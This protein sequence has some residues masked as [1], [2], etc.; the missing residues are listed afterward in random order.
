MTNF[1][2]SLISEQS[3]SVL[4][5]NLQ[6][7]FENDSR[8]ISGYIKSVKLLKEFLDKKHDSLAMDWSGKIVS[9]LYLKSEF[10]EWMQ[11]LKKV[12][13]NNYSGNTINAY[14][15][16]LKN[17]T[18][19]LALTQMNIVTD[20]FFYSE[21]DE[22]RLV[23]E[24]ILSAPNL[25]DIN[26]SARNGAYTTALPL[27]L[28]F[29]QNNAK[30]SIWIF[31]GN[32]KYYDVAG[33]INDLQQITWAVN[34]STKQIKQG[35]KVYIWI[36]GANSGIIASGK[37]LCN[38]EMRKP[39]LNDPYS[40]GESLKTDDYLA[41]DIDITC[42][43][44]ETILRSVLLND[45]RT[46]RLE[47]LTYPGATNFK[48]TAEQDEVVESLIN[49][50]YKKVDV[51]DVVLLKV[52]SQRRY[53]LYSPGEQASLWEEFHNNQIMG[54]GWDDLG[55][56]TEYSSKED[57]KKAMRN[58]SG[59]NKSYMNDG[60]ALWQFANDISVGDVV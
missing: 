48:V 42:K 4:I 27:Y 14:I 31:Q 55:I 32:P 44:K 3:I 36:S 20:L 47:I 51:M 2:T 12:D 50:T 58:L 41:V 56:L 33:A 7:H 54:I 10:K 8:R 53:W 5:E 39:D 60:L 17:S 22:F 1:W 46:K 18:A 37:I 26:K 40:K 13:G 19:K 24:I 11:K 29:L 16:A 38:P 6:K 52:E 49:S 28:E 34:Q 23:Y 59:E 25:T 30:A 21:P 43:L 57:V 9:S 35:D 45:E 15:S